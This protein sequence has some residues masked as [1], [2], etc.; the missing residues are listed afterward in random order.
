MSIQQVL[1]S[2]AWS[3]ALF[4]VSTL[5]LMPSDGLAAGAAYESDLVLRAEAVFG[6]LRTGVAPDA[7]VKCGTP[8]AYE[9]RMAWPNL[10]AGARERLSEIV[11]LAERPQLDEFYDVDTPE[12]DF[13]IHY[14][15][16]G[17]H[18]IDMS[19]GVGEGNV[20]V[21]VLKC[22]AY[23]DTTVRVEITELGYRFPVS[24]QL[25]NGEEDPRYD[26][27]FLNLGPGFYGLTV[28]EAIVRPGGTGPYLSTSYLQLNSDY[29]RIFGYSDR[30]FDAMAV[31]VAHEFNHAVQWSYDAA[32]AELRE[33][34]GGGDSEFYPWFFELT[35]T[36]LED[37]VFDYVN[38]YQLYLPAFFDYPWMSLRRFSGG[39]NAESLHPYASCIWGFYLRE[40]LDDE[41]MREFW[42]VC[43]S[44]PG[45]NTFQAFEEVLQSRG[46]SFADEWGEFLVWNYFT[47]DRAED[48]SYSEGADFDRVSGFGGKVPDSLIA[49]FDTYPLDTATIAVMQGIKVRPPHHSDEFGA[50]YMRFVPPDA[51][52]DVPDLNL[53]IT[54]DEFSE[55]LIVTAGLR[56]GL[57]PVIF[58][59]Q[60]FFDPVV[61]S[62]WSRFDEV[63]V[64]VS[65]FNTAPDQEILNLNLGFGVSVQDSVTAGAKKSAVSAVYANPFDLAASEEFPF[66]VLVTLAEPAPISMHI[67]TTSGELVAGGEEDGMYASPG[68]RSKNLY[69]TGKNRAGKKV[70]SGVYLALVQIGDK[71]EIVKVA[72]KNSE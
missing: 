71:Q 51:G 1:R 11:Q 57:T 63:L 33:P 6:G 15:R 72:V 2:A 58:S 61:V 53:L 66:G 64:V 24:D 22:A 54:P 69:W 12:G 36:Y 68:P 44:D 45:F 31:T 59:T 26:V 55:C 62:D 39:S 13:R 42:D 28:S 20:P 67:F 65:P 32:E 9:I 25:G 56:A 3:L 60:D 5:L 30:P 16:T 35:S 34:P 40:T 37:V 8:L 7:P 10:S 18:A 50:T 70:V 46:S 43:G 52:G 17:T 23:I 19:F 47:G 4:L 21:Y 48:W 27:Y 29:K 41:V 14:T 49:T 38:D